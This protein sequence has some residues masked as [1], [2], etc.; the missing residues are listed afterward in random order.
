MHRTISVSLHCGPSE[1]NGNGVEEVVAK[2]AGETRIAE[3][4]MTVAAISGVQRL[5]PADTC[6]A[7]GRVLSPAH[8]VLV[9][10]LLLLHRDASSPVFAALRL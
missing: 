4:E 9:L 10:V 3:V 2:L 6:R 1:E 5:K 8:V 7:V